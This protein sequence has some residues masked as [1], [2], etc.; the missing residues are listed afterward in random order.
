MPRLVKDPHAY[1]RTLVADRGEEEQ[2]LAAEAAARGIPVAGPVLGQLLALLCRVMGAVRVLE[3]GAAVGYSTV[4]LARAMRDTGGVV[5]SIDMHEAHCREAR[6]NLAAS[7]LEDRC[8]MLCADARNLPLGGGGFDLVF[9][10]VDQRYYAELEP[11]CHDL[12]RSGGLLVADN[13]SFADA[14][15][16]NSLIRDGGRWDALNIYAFLPNHAPEQDGICL[17]RKKNTGDT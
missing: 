2:R 15:A 14:G 10:D 11:A 16:F 13:T 1:F 6:A 12:L 9:L 3:L 17:A 8:T 4:F 5:L 7:G